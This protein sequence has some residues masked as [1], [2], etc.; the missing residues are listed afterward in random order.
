MKNTTRIPAMIL[1]VAIF[2]AVVILALRTSVT[3][4][5]EF[6]RFQSV[7]FDVIRDIDHNRTDLDELRLLLQHQPQELYSTNF[8]G[9]LPIHFAAKRGL[10]EALPMLAGDDKALVNAKTEA[11][12][13]YIVGGR[14]PLHFAA[15]IGSVD[16]VL[17][18]L[19][20]GADPSALD[21]RG[22][23]PL[24]YARYNPHNEVVDILQSLPNYPLVH[25]ADDSGH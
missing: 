16:C 21:D 1:L 22:N 20:L 10:C 19:N 14:T 5:R 25:P 18:L 7:I 4:E 13:E 2:A 12:V 23:S 11:R 24:I 8:S 15:S 3:I 17:T 9:F 6:P